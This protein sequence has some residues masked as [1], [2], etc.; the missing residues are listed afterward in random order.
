MEGSVTLP[1]SACYEWLSYPLDENR[2]PSIPAAAATAAYAGGRLSSSSI[3]S[4]A[5]AECA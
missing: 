5:M 1:L 3:A 4:S 2:A